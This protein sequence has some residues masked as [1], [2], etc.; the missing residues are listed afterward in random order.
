MNVLKALAQTLGCFVLGVDHFGKNAE[1]GTRGAS[2]KESASELVLACLGDK[3]VNSGVSNTRLTV[4]KNRGGQQSQEF[5]FTL[6]VVEAPEADDDGEPVTSGGNQAQPDP[7][8]QTRRQDQ[9]AAVLRLKRVMMGALA[10]HRVER[11]IPPDGPAAWMIDHEVVRGLYYAQTRRMA[12]RN[13][14][15]TLG[16]SNSNGRWTGP[17]PRD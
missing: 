16:A 4:R 6:R 5:P 2:S 3:S 7:W 14:R 1:A 17:K 10:E 12:R 15:P 8:A 9:R 13:T 11:K